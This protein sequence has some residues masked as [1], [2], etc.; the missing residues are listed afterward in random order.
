V[1]GGRPSKRTAQLTEAIKESLACGLSFA[2]TAARSNISRD[3]LNE[4]L[5]N[6]QFA[7]EV[8]GAMA[9]RKFQCIQ[10]ILSGK[11]FFGAAWWLERTDL[12]WAKPE[13]QW[14]MQLHQ[15]DPVEKPAIEE[16]LIRSLTNYHAI[17][18]NGQ[19]KEEPKEVSSEA[20]RVDPEQG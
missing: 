11:N 15:N 3:T 1:P 14:A 12:R 8:A 16:A 19:R 17:K 20:Q 13:L 10:T 9:E 5:K 2:E 4:W 18:Q 7:D 6:E